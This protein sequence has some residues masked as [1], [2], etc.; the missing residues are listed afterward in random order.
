[1]GYRAGIA[2]LKQVTTFNG[3][4]R[5]FYQLSQSSFKWNLPDTIKDF[6]AYMMERFLFC[7]GTV[8]VFDGGKAGK[9]ILPAYPIEYSDIEYVPTVYE[10]V[11]QGYQK[12]LE[13][14]KD[15]F[16][17]IFND[18]THT[19]SIDICEEYARII[20]NIE[21]TDQLNIMQL[22]VPWIFGSDED[23]ANSLKAA[24]TG[25]LTGQV[26]SFVTKDVARLL[27]EGFNFAQ[28]GVK[29]IGDDMKKHRDD[30]YNECLT[31]LGIDNVPIT[32][33]ERLITDEAEGNNQLIYTFRRDRLE[34]RRAQLGEASR[35]LG[36]EISVEWAGG[37]NNGD[38]SDSGLSEG[39]ANVSMDGRG[40][41]VH[42]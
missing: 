42:D 20:A 19:G 17:L 32:K 29:Y 38:V 13:V 23:T 25:I 3:V 41:A 39:A 8:A 37:E 28:T 7:V 11:G 18:S 6:P 15:D 1:M 9:L 5:D 12:R 35:I 2:Q 36:G 34:N 10:A 21:G 33:K 22:R 27:S 4:L 24:I 40:D 14:G 26:A 16:A 31:K 30:K